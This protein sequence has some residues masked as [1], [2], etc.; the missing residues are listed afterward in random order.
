MLN[1]GNSQDKNVSTT[2]LLGSRVD[3]VASIGGTVMKEVT[4]MITVRTFE[5]K[6][7]VL[8][9]VQTVRYKDVSPD[10]TEAVIDFL[11]KTEKNNY[12]V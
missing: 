12:A 3:P 9:R 11:E 8:V 7:G 6:N 5:Y 1:P 10:H 4:S 2:R